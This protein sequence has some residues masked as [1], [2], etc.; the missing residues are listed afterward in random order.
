MILICY[1]NNINN[2][3]E[4]YYNI[5][6][7]LLLLCNVILNNEELN[8]NQNLTALQI[9][10]L[11]F[12]SNLSQHATIQILYTPIN[13]LSLLNLNDEINMTEINEIIS[14]KRNKELNIKN[15]I[16]EV[17]NKQLFSTSTVDIK[18]KLISNRIL[19]KLYTLCLS[20]IY[21]IYNK[22]SVYRKYCN[23]MLQYK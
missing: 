8:I 17:I 10:E 4:I 14:R 19:G 2:I 6:E 9:L 21:I 22:L 20:N 5:R 13:E 3:N 23:K 12:N 15:T 7:N 18:Y 1:F 11:L 16:S